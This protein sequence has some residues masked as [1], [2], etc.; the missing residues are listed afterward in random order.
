MGLKESG[1]WKR[2][3]VGED[4]WASQKARYEG[5][6]ERGVLHKYEANFFEHALTLTGGA[7][8]GAGEP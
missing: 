4:E 6:E 1:G 2:L 8:A 3:E 7:K 5:E